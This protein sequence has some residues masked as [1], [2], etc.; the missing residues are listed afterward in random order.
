MTKRSPSRTSRV[1]TVSFPPEL[2]HQV[3]AL[4]KEE[5]RSISELFREAFRTYKSERRHR[6]LET[7]R[8]EAAKHG[9]VP[10][11]E[12]DIQAIVDEI[13]AREYE[14]RKKTA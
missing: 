3:D 9:P 12:E 6:K 4:A 11:T 13:R 14:R 7:A 1:F 5:C 2:A 10:Y 8:A